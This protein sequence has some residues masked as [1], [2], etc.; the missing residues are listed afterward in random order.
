MVEGE[1]MKKTNL[2]IFYPIFL[3]LLLIILKYPVLNLPYYWD[4]LNYMIPTIEHIYNN[5]FTPFLWDYNLGHPPFFFW[6]VAVLFK[7]FGTSNL[8]AH[9]AVVLFSFLTLYFTYLIGKELFNRKVG[10]ISSLTL[11]FTPIFFSYSG[12]LFLAIPLT[13]FATMTIYFAIKSKPFLYFIFGSL[14][15]LTKLPAILVIGGVTLSKLMKEKKINKTVI[16]SLLPFI[17]FLLLAI[18]NKFYYGEFL[19][20]ISS[21][22]L[23]EF[24]LVK[25]LLNLL[26]IL[27]TLLFD[28]YRW[29]LTSFFIISFV[30]FKELKNI[31][32]DFFIFSLILGILFFFL[33]YNLNIFT[34]SLMPYF[35]NIKTYF[36]TVK[37]FSL[38]FS[39]LFLLILFSYKNL[40]NHFKKK[41]FLEL[42]ITFLLTVLFYTFL[43]PFSPRYIVPLLPILFLF[44]SFSLTKLSGKYSYLIVFIILIIFSLNFIGDRSTVGFTLETNMEYVDA[45]KTQQLGASYIEKNFPDATVLASFPLSSELQHPYGG[46]VKKPINV[47]TYPHFPGMTGH[48]KNYTLFL[49]PELYVDPVIDINTIDLYYYTPQEFPSKRVLDIVQKLNLTPIKRFELNNKAVEIYLVNK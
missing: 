27:K 28:Q 7:I 9:S 3:F 5:S 16:V 45:I 32:K 11:L 12:L 29:I 23:V 18:S 39:I 31:K 8:V 30:K 48:K 6:F 33:L 36:S 20:P 34:G 26:I 14:A 24:N 2:D 10:I 13:A 22:S 43:I 25:T 21:T 19:N 49:N 37:S 41:N 1:I 17:T 47:I 35:P 42:H 15:I 44:Y 40:I 4:D 38:L 46:Y